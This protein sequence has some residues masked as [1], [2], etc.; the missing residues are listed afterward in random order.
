MKKAKAQT[1]KVHA[2]ELATLAT[3][4]VARKRG[5]ETSLEV[6]RQS[7]ALFHALARDFAHASGVFFD[8]DLRFTAEQGNGLISLGGTVSL[9]GKTPADV[10]SPELV[11]LIEPHLH[12]ALR[13]DATTFEVP[14][15]KLENQN[16][17]AENRV[18]LM[19]ALPVRDEKGVITGG[20]AV[21]QDLRGHRLEEDE[22]QSFQARVLAQVEDAVNVIDPHQRVIYWNNAAARL[23]GVDAEDALGQ[24]LSEIYHYEWLNEGGRPVVLQELERN[25]YWQGECLHRLAKDGREILVEAS[26]SPLREAEGAPAGFLAVIRDI[27]ARKKG[28][29]SRARLENERDELLQRLRCEIEETHRLQD[30]LNLQFERMPIGCIVWDRD[31][32]VESWN[33]AAST[34]FGYSF[35]EVMGQHAFKAIVPPEA[36]PLIDELW[37][38]LISGDTTANSVNENITRDGRRIVCQWSNTPLFDHDGT[39]SGVLSM[40]QD[41]TDRVQA[42]DNLRVSEERFRSTFEKAAVGVAHIGNDG[43][44][45]QVNRKLCEILGYSR[46]EMLAGM[47]FQDITH[48]DDLERN[49]TLFEKALTK[50]LSSYAM[51]KR[52]LHKTGR[53]VW[54]NLTASLVDAPDS[55]PYFVAV[56]EDITARKRAERSQRLLAEASAAFASSLDYEATLRTLARLC[57]EELAEIC[58]VDLVGRGVA[59][60]WPEAQEGNIRRVAARHR[61]E[62]QKALMYKLVEYPPHLS[63]GLPDREALATGRTIYVEDLDEELFRL[64]AHDDE[65]LALMQSLNVKA[66]IVAPLIARGRVIGLVKLCNS[67]AKSFDRYDISLI[68]ELMRRAALALENA[69]LYGQAQQARREAEAASRAKDEFLAVVSHELRTPLTPILGWVS[70][71]RDDELAGSLDA[72]T[73][74]HAL[75]AIQQG[76]E[77]QSQIIDDLL[78]VSRIISGNA[79]LHT[80]AIRLRGVVE[81]A[82]AVARPSANKKEIQFW[83]SFDPELGHD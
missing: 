34:I 53:V 1:V 73:R 78:D 83:T 8:H 69:H 32:R 81:A 28:E 45:V 72:E 29:E 33:P 49:V 40:V 50:N 75:D 54:G 52:Y 4:I 7:R 48:P 20:L 44:W 42:E 66:C 43:R 23:Y 12:A 76:A 61:D 62:S 10:F 17:Q 56:I 37:Q 15:A 38:R 24:P 21:A 82:L 13:G 55:E 74:L 46:D 77:V 19:R 47:R 35:N 5:L 68:E 18:L 58:L 60:E 39:V 6:L 31:F 27:T 70:M 63:K 30:H 64:S 9:P 59:V 65:H 2:P 79:H 16:G 67:T 57:A 3:Q 26:I 36:Q 14:L 80:H 22:W 25:G 51:E 71:L 41:I 11:A